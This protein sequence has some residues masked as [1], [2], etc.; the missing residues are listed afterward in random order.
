GSI[1]SW[2]GSQAYH[3]VGAVGMVI[4]GC[5]FLLLAICYELIKKQKNLMNQSRRFVE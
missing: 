4:S 3:I 5:A 2:V 1:G